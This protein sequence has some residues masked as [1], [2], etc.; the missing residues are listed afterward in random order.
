VRHHQ[1]AHCLVVV[2]EHPH[3]ILGVGGLGEGGEA[4]QVQEHDD[5]LAPAGLQRV[6]GGP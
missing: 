5:D 6:I 2:A 4:A 3:H 1:L